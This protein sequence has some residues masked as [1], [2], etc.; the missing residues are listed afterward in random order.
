MA[1][2]GKINLA[3]VAPNHPF[4]GRTIVFMPKPQ[5]L[6]ELNQSIVLDQHAQNA[7]PHKLEEIEPV[8]KTEGSPALRLKTPEWTRIDPPWWQIEF[9]VRSCQGEMD[10]GFGEFCVLS[11]LGTNTYVQSAVSL[12]KSPDEKNAWRIEW[13]ITEFDGTYT[14][15]FARNPSDSADAKTVVDIGIVVIAFKSFYQNKGMPDSLVWM[16]YDI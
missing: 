6:G 13:R 14:H 10:G 4:V 15:Y 1:L 2:L 11:Q 7:T 5:N 12:G 3:E 9:A 8:K 16:K